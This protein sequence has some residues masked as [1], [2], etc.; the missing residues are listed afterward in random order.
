LRGNERG[1]LGDE[2]VPKGIFKTGGPLA[3][4]TV[5]G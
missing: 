4:W 3:L 2:P 5:E 1:L